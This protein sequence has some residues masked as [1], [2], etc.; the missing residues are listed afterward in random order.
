MVINCKNCGKEKTI[1]PSREGRQL[2]CNTTCRVTYGWNG[3]RIAWNKGKSIRSNTGRTHFKKGFTPWNKGIKGSTRTGVL[4]HNWKEEDYSYDAVHYWIVRHYGSAVRCDKE[5]C[6]Y[7][8]KTKNGTILP[9]AKK[10]CWSNLSGEYKRD[11]T[12]WM[13]MCMSCNMLHDWGKNVIAKRFPKE[14]QDR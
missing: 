11:I 5:G 1:F 9:Y 4:H 2:F 12:D 7:P 6:S 13:Q 8:K 10:F 14:E 3:D